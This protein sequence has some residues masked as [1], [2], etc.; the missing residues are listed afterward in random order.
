M[1][2]RMFDAPGDHCCSAAIISSASAQGPAETLTTQNLTL[3]SASAELPAATLGTFP[4]HAGVLGR[5]YGRHPFI[6]SLVDCAASPNRREGTA[7]AV[8]SS[9][10][11]GPRLDVGCAISFK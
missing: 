2:E 7:S 1:T 3:V 4:A 6:S 5:D 10:G 11:L 8:V 9:R